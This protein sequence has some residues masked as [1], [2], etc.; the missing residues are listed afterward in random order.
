MLL[1]HVCMADHLTTEHEAATSEVKDTSANLQNEK[2]STG[3]GT[4]REGAAKGDD[5]SM[6][7]GTD[8]P[9]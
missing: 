6:Q 7:Q 5:I 3:L 4:A 9:R 8:E 2:H 1:M